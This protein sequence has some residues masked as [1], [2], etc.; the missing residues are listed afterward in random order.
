MLSQEVKDVK[1]YQEVGGSL[2]V[3]V[4]AIPFKGEVSIEISKEEKEFRQSIEVQVSQE[5]VDSWRGA[6]FYFT[7][8]GPNLKVICQEKTYAIFHVL[9][10]ALKKP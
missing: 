1:Q 7:Q 5:K 10:N 9:P 3:A 8:G 2:K 6:R 4:K